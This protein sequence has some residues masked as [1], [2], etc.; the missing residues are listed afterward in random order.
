MGDRIVALIDA[1]N[2]RRPPTEQKLS[3]QRLSLL[4]SE[5]K[6]P[7]V[8]RDLLKREKAGDLDAGIDAE[9]L[10][11]IAGFFGVTP[12]YLRTG[13][14][15]I[16]ALNVTASPFPV[17]LGGGGVGQPVISV[18]G[19]M[20]GG[21]IAEEAAQIIN[22]V[23]YAADAVRGEIFMPTFILNSLSHHARPGSVHWIEVR[24]DSMEP[25]LHSG[26]WVAI[27][28]GDRN[29]GQGG[30]FA[31]RDATGGIVVK[32]VELSD[33]PGRVDILSDNPRHST[34]RE[35]IGD[36]EIIG[37]VFGRISRVG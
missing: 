31:L 33:Q 10:L 12:S 20:G 9:R 37:R 22:G 15:D 4:A 21:G 35:L 17:Q 24:G 14:S 11:R 5:G 29:I 6:N 32:R 2:R 13:Q 19:G 23:K 26:D 7:D 8:V 36:I 18:T 27:V 25:T 3:A 1:Y 30:I 28:V 16:D 34:R